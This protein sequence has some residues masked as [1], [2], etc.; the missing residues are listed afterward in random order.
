MGIDRDDTVI[1]RRLRQKVEFLSDDAAA[2]I[3]PTDEELKKFVEENPEK[4]RK[5][6]SYSFQQVYINADKHADGGKADAEAKLSKILAGE[7]VA[8]DSV[9]LA[10]VLDKAD[11]REVDATFGKGFAEKLDDLE[12]GSWTGPIR[13]GLGYHLVKLGQR[14]PGEIPALEQIRPIAEREWSNL[15]RIEVGEAVYEGLRAEY[16]IVIEWP[17]KENSK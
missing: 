5:E 16:N 13:S 11:E 1:R 17:E 12:V 15:K 9:L 10:Q 2:L 8:S 3:K 7:D 14:I 4:F 6:T